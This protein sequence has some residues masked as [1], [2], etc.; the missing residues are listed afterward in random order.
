MDELPHIYQTT[1]RAPAQ[2]NVELTAPGLPALASAAPPEFGGPGDVWSPE[3]LLTAAVADCF[4]LGFRAIARASKL[5]WEHLECEVK[6]QLDRVEKV[7][8]FTRFDLK[9]H[10]KAPGVE[11]GRAMRILERA[12]KTCLI[13]NSLTAEVHLEASVGG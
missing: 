12:E 1:A 2:G 6:G 3:T 13:T 9:V 5:E 11:E 8:K 4:V 10:L 7:L